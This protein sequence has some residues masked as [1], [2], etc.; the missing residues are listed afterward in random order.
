MLCPSVSFR[1]EHIC[2]RPFRSAVPHS[3]DH[4]PFS[5]EPDRQICRVAPPLL[6]FAP[7]EPTVR[8]YRSAL[9][10]AAI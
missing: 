6:A 1:F 8:R 9:Q 2:C 5:H 10:N 4:A 3:F 7:T